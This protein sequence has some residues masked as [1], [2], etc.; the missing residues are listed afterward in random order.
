M[1]VKNTTSTETPRFRNDET[2][3]KL[4]KHSSSSEDSLPSKF[5]VD[6]DK[7][8]NEIVN[9]EVEKFSKRS[10]IEKKNLHQEDDF[11]KYQ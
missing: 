2:N 11:K 1:V 3:S 6:E 7:L 5:S 10:E 8:L 4:N 9:L